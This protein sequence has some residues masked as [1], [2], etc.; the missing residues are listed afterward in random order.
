M[1]GS[2]PE[3]YA[4]LELSSDEMGPDRITQ[5]LGLEPSMTWRRGDQ[6]RDGRTRQ[7]HHWV[8]KTP[9]RPSFDFDEPLQQLLGWLAPSTEA[10]RELTQGPCDVARICLVGYIRDTTPGVYL[11]GATVQTIASLGADLQVDLFLVEGR[12]VLPHDERNS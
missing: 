5:K 10:L 9:S 6:W 3:I 2:E 1:S 7:E 8:L 4:E 11:E 12:T